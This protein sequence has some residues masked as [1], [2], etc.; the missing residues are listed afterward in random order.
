[1]VGVGVRQEL[2]VLAKVALV[3]LLVLA[4][5]L[6]QVPLVMGDQLFYQES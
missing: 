3:V 2:L 4:T 6:L 1:M 5:S